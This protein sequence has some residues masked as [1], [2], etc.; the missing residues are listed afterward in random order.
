MS[1]I[2]CVAL[3]GKRNVPVDALHLIGIWFRYIAA[4]K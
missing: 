1:V 4:W 3:P 2:V